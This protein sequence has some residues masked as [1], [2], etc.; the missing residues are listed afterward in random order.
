MFSLPAP[1][2]AMGYKALLAAISLLGLG[3][4]ILIH[5]L[6]HF[7]FGKLFDVE[8]TSFSIGFGPV[9][10][11]KKWGETDFIISAL[12]FGGFV[13][14]TGEDAPTSRKNKRSLSNKPFLQRSLIFMGGI[15]FNLLLAYILCRGLSLTRLPDTL[16]TRQMRETSQLSNVLPN[17]AA[18]KAGLK[19]GDRI[20]SFG[21]LAATSSPRSTLMCARDKSPASLSISFERKGTQRETIAELSP[22]T[23]LGI[24]F[25]LRP[26]TQLSVAEK[27]NR[28]ITLTHWMIKDSA[29]SLKRIIKSGNARCLAGP[30]GMISAGAQTA[31]SGWGSFIFFIA[32]I[33]V[34]LAFINLLPLPILDGG[35]LLLAAIESGRGRPLSEKSRTILG[36]TCWVFFIL[37]MLY[38]TGNDILRLIRG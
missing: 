13:D 6:G 10:F 9:L 14:F 25:E 31:S 16:L 11:K 30:I 12:P 33:S 2:L 28:G 29:Q 22:D 38:I 8:T 36:Y 4:V 5:E 26:E 23:P 37:L 20:I 35:Q 24:E 7:L 15:L 3:F 17:S 27:I 19:A 34:G 21:G 1:L 18:K 32:L